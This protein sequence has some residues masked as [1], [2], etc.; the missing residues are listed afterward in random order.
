MLDAAY[1]RLPLGD[2]TGRPWR[3]RLRAVAGENR[4]LYQAHSWRPRSPLCGPHS[5]WG[6]A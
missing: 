1:Q 6:R 4:A 5:D 2:T 3:Q